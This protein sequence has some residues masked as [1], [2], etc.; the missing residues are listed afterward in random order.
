MDGISLQITQYTL[1]SPMS[2][3]YPGLAQCLFTAFWTKRNLIC[4]RNLM[5]RKILTVNNSSKSFSLLINGLGG[6]G[7][8]TP[9]LF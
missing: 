5:Q 3:S 2:T 6:G 7:G 8:L 1:T 4:G 9:Q